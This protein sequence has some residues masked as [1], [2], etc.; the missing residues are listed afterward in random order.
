[1][2]IILI[3]IAMLFIASCS[4]SPRHTVDIDSAVDGDSTTVEDV[5]ISDDFSDEDTAVTDDITD[6]ITDVTDDPSDQEETDV[7]DDIDAAEEG[8]PDTADE[9]LN[10]DTTDDPIDETADEDIIDEDLIDE[11]II[12]EDTVPQD[13]PVKNL[14]GNQ[15]LY[16]VAYEGS[17][18]LECGGV[19][20]DQLY[21]AHSIPYGEVITVD[22]DP[23]T[24][25]KAVAT[26]YSISFLLTDG[27]LKVWG[28][29][30]EKWPNGATE[31]PMREASMKLKNIWQVSPT[32]V[33]GVRVD[34][35][36]LVQWGTGYMFYDMYV[37]MSSALPIYS[38]DPEAGHTWSSITGV[39]DAGSDC[40]I[41]EA[42]IWC[43]RSNRY[44]NN[45][46]GYDL[47]TRSD[48]KYLKSKTTGHTPSLSCSG[49][50]KELS[51]SQCVWKTNDK[52]SCWGLS[53]L[54]EVPWV[55]STK[56]EAF[57]SM[58]FGSELEFI[59]QEGTNLASP[60]QLIN[61][62]HLQLMYTATEMWTFVRG[63]FDY[64]TGMGPV[65]LLSFPFGNVKEVFD[66]IGE[67]WMILTEDGEVWA[68]K[69]ETKE[70]KRIQLPYSEK[71]W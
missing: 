3:I 48:G 22:I 20:A 34:D 64:E 13:P 45:S 71:T 50:S 2:K 26:T 4:G 60:I 36:E 12:D 56:T 46:D 69:A 7:I 66:G 10:D 19:S 57:K 17:T 52:L 47:I 49:S 9:E 65:E 15:A 70:F 39:T 32:T 55:A 11:D 31:M 8:I 14:Y 1:M 44:G 29:P 37:I 61:G 58:H 43:N 16:C 41:I 30:D 27:T 6:D 53:S 51:N 5:D 62:S 18:N 24:I 25:V 23:E 40:V 28:V 68:L 21:A 42:S 38:R 54:D 63:S 35:D 59:L 67:H 33:F